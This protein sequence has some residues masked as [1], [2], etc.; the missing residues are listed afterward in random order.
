MQAGRARLSARGA[1]ALAVALWAAPAQA[2]RF[3]YTAHAAA[4]PLVRLT[5]SEPARVQADLLFQ[6]VF[7]FAED[8][9]V[10][11]PLFIELGPAALSLGVAVEYVYF[12]DNHWR[13]DVG[14]GGLLRFAFQSLA[15]GGGPYLKAS[16]RWLFAWGLGAQLGVHAVVQ[17]TGPEPVPTFLLVPTLGLYQEFW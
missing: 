15:F 2:E 1:L 7:G 10:E 5:P 16:V 17:V 8:W 9:N 12:H 11:V 13:L 6:S 3:L 14:L 4:G